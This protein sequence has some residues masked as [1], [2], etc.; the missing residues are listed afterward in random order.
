LGAYFL[1][2]GNLPWEIGFFKARWRHFNQVYGF[3][4]ILLVSQPFK[5]SGENFW[6]FSPWILM[7]AHLKKALS[8]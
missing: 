2:G 4:K 3:K 1:L 8:F 5:F 6:E 7:G